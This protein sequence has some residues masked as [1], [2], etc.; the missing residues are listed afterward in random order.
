MDNSGKL[1]FPLKTPPADFQLKHG[2]PES[3]AQISG[4]ARCF[5]ASRLEDLFDSLD[6]ALFSMAEHTTS[7]ADQ[8][9]YFDSLGYLRRQRQGFIQNYI[10]RLDE[11]YLERLDA[12]SE[13]SL[14]EKA[15]KSK[16][17]LVRDDDL[18]ARLSLENTVRRYN[19]KFE[20]YQAHLLGQLCLAFEGLEQVD[21]AVPF[22]PDAL[23]R[24]FKY[25][26]DQLELDF[27][28]NLMLWKHFESDVLAVLAV[29]Y[30]KTS[31]L[32]TDFG[33]GIAYQNSSNSHVVNQDDRLINFVSLLFEYIIDDHL[34]PTAVRAL[35]S[36]LQIPV[37][38]LS[39]IDE[40]F[41]RQRA[42]P[43]R[44]LLNGLASVGMEL[45]DETIDRGDPVFT[46]MENIVD[47]L[48]TGFDD[49][50]RI[51]NVVFQDFEDNVLPLLSK[52]HAKEKNK[53]KPASQEKPRKQLQAS[54]LAAETKQRRPK[55][56]VAKDKKKLSDKQ[57]Q[58]KMT[59]EAT[60]EIVLQTPLDSHPYS[61][62]TK[63]QESEKAANL[64]Y[65]LQQV[66][67]LR[68][69]Q[70]VEFLGQKGGSLR[71][72]LTSIS[73]SDDRYVF[74]NSQGMRVVEQSAHELAQEIHDG[75]F[76]ILEDDL[77]FDKALQSVL[78]NFKLR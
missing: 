37:L 61:P 19:R 27:R 38:K 74:E 32:L 14:S 41:F 54:S 55:Q 67:K 42:H 29:L 26:M 25:A 15:K 66:T 22:F 75:T 28:V 64:K 52:A 21:D 31:Q 39:K 57:V 69:G 40:L 11:I 13:A 63:P 20:A 59:A 68:K 36:R 16:L 5:L 24:N 48:L 47:R 23:C 49:D 12:E 60:E 53:R 50:P 33:H 76:K 8:C 35:L 10:V 34:L 4:V 58:E 1:S 71:C 70:W 65:Q 62:R 9:I 77:L 73:K 7:S 18:D 46:R 51:F 30:E 17:H 45:S 44:R 56:I 3:V 6:D 72:R 43:A 78:G 2:L